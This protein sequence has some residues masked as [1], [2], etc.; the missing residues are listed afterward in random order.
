MG[1]SGQTERSSPNT[2]TEIEAARIVIRRRWS[3]RRKSCGRRS[4]LS[5]R[6][7][8]RCCGSP[9]STTH[10]LATLRP[11][12]AAHRTPSPRRCCGLDELLRRA[13]L[14]QH[15]GAVPLNGAADTACTAARPLL[16]DY[17]RGVVGN[18]Q[19]RHIEQHLERCA[20]CDEECRRLGRLNRHLRTVPLWPAIL[21]TPTPTAVGLKAQLVAW[22]TSAATPLAASGALAI[23][24]FAPAI[25]YDDLVPERT[26]AP[27]VVE[28]ERVGSREHCA[29]RSGGGG[30]A[31]DGD[32][33]R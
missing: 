22:F 25:T 23:T 13:Y 11:S 5:R 21:G 4:S 2:R 8:G 17:V 28:V 33:Y 15:L 14:Q 32:R 27:A 18:C 3:P 26:S 12:A 10:V 29:D 31:L 30:D 19:R 7:S 20:A 9:K 1:V 24:A 6:T 16:V